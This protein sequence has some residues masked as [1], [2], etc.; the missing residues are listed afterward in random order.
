[1]LPDFVDACA[2]RLE[3][4]DAVDD[5]R[6]AVAECLGIDRLPRAD[7]TPRVV[8][9]IGRDAYT[10]EKLVFETL[11]GLPVPALLYLPREPSQPL[12]AVVHAPGHWMENAKLEPELQRT[13]AWLARSGVAV[14]CHDTLGEGERRVGWH[15]HGQL[16][17]LLV[18]FTTLA[19]MV[20]ESRGAL[21]LLAGRDEIDAS[22]LG[23]LGA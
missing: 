14:L 3:R 12:P 8:G 5:L 22:R 20:A 18:G 4:L 7:V 17:T 1:M 9:T 13:N 2:A 10:I 21:D 15:Q 6:E 16:G 19:A 23:V 11:P